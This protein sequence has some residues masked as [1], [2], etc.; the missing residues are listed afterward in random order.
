MTRKSIFDAAKVLGASITSKLDVAIMDAAIDE[1]VAH[2]DDPLKSAA[3]NMVEHAEAD[4][5]QVLASTKEARAEVER[6]ENK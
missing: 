6:S 4:A 2:V 5:R 1:G 3:L